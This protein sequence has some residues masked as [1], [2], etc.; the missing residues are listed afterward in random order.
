MADPTFRVELLSQST[1]A[2]FNF[3]IIGESL[4][5][6]TDTIPPA[7]DVWADVSEDVRSVVISR[8]RSRDID[9]FTAGTCT[10]RVDNH[11]RRFDPTNTESDL[12]GNIEPMRQLRVTA[13]LGG[14][15]YPLY[16]GFV[17]S[18]DI[19]ITSGFWSEVD[20]VCADA[21]SVLANQNM[22]AVAE[23]HDGDLPGVRIGRVLDAAEVA[24]PAGLRDI[25][26]GLTVL[27]D[28]TFGENALG[29]LQKVGQSEPGDL[30]VTT[31]G[32]LRFVERNG[33]DTTVQATFSDDGADTGYVG[34]GQQFDVDLLSN[35]VR[36][37]GVSGTVQTA[38]DTN[39]QVT[40]QVRNLDRTG[41]L[42]QS[43]VDAASQASF[44]LGRFARP[45]FRFSDVSAN[46]VGLSDA[47]AAEL[48]GLEL[49]D[50]VN[51]EL[52]PPGGGAQIVQAALIDRL[53]WGISSGGRV[54]SLSA[55]VSAGQSAV[56]FVIGDDQLGVIGKS[57][58]AF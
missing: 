39:S 43:D 27:G 40:Y 57:L 8:G 23:A 17:Q 37:S 10:V 5:G 48:L 13:T 18:W 25:D 2:F 41:L 12:Y 58:I 42:M 29:Y 22:D 15:D 4:I 35:R 16:R 45:E 47:R 53:S 19:G 26:A 3:F 46:I 6:G 44:L 28:T 9:N 55:S 49:A 14:T 21:F 38:D 51:V 24:F 52:T 50:R 20:I 31:S 36:V 32:A 54:V 30:F 7:A 56:G 11:T 1:S 33:R 34:I